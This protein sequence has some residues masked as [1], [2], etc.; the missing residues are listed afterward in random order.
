MRLYNSK[1]I[2]DDWIV[3]AKRFTNMSDVSPIEYENFLDATYL[4]SQKANFIK[5][6]VNK[7]KSLNNLIVRVNAIYTDDAKAHKADSDIAKSF[8]SQLFLTK[9]AKVIF[10]A[11]L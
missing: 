2:V 8:E 9:D 10:R 3:L 4:F 1:F 6:N 11:N 7:L 5:F